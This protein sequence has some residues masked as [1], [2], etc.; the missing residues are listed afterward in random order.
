MKITFINLYE[1]ERTHFHM[2][3]FALRLVLK[4]RQGRS[5]KWPFGM[6]SLQ[7]KC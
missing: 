1:N 5:W 3:G 4:Q 7:L 6:K 2:E